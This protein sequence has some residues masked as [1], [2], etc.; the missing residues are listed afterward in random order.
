MEFFYDHAIAELKIIEFNPRLGSQ[1]ADLYNRVDGRNVF[2]MQLALA[3][4]LDPLSVEQQQTNQTCA[5]SFVFR[6]FN[7]VQAPAPLTQTT[8]D[9]F[10]S[11]FPDALLFEF[12]KSAVGLAREY[13]WLGSH[14]YGI[15][16]LSGR[17]EADLQSKF[18]A[19]AQLLGWDCPE[20]YCA[21]EV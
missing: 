20:Q 1:L 3:Q 11:A 7:G 6:R 19:A 16:H 4:G 17:D 9:A 15:F 8:R 18:E 13:K 2:L 5:A 14:R 21:A 10:K 12:R